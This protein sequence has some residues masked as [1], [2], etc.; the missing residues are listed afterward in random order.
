MLKAFASAKI[1]LHL[2]ITGREAGGYHQLDSLVAFTGLKDEITIR[3]SDRFSL[4]I[5]GKTI[6]CSA[7][8]N[9]ISRATY[10][11]AS[12]FKVAPNINVSLVKNIPLAAGLGGGSA[13]AATTLLLLKEFW[14]IASNTA[15]KEIAADLGSDIVACLYG[16]PVIM[17]ET[18]N[19]ILPAP[20]LPKLYA[21]LVNP[22]VACPTPLVYKTYAHATHQFSDDIVFPASFD[23]AQSL[24]AFLSVHTTNDLTNAAI[25]VAPEIQT[26]LT[27][28]ENLPN[29]LLTRLSGSGATCFALFDTMDAA[30]EYASTVKKNHPQWWVMPT[31]IN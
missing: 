27:E 8:D 19:N 25:E 17:R 16:K 9:L 6:D 23:T 31:T 26:V 22:N 18:G 30:N 5:S 20:K 11:L 1:N 24:C 21:L 2:H 15:I 10:S 7:Q 12:Q 3:P 14:N 4:N 13:D 29:C 28:L